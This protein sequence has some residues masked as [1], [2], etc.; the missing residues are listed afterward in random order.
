[1]SQEIPCVVILNK[2]KYHLFSFTKFE[3]RREKHVLPKGVGTNWKRKEVG[4]GDGRMNMVQI[5]YTHACK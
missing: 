4:K 2:Q 3:N 5:L 1:M